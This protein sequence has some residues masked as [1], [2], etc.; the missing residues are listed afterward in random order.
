MKCMGSHTFDSKDLGR[1]GSE[2]WNYEDDWELACS[3]LGTIGDKGM[4]LNIAREKFSALHLPLIP[5]VNRLRSL[6]FPNGERWKKEDS[7]LYLK[8]K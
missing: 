6:V 1:T 2:S 7:D 3:K 8:M 4:F 5:C